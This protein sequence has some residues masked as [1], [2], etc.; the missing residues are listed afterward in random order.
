MDSSLLSQIQKGSR[1]KKAVTNDR[2]APLV[3]G[4]PKT[5]A[6]GATPLSPVSRDSGSASI[7]VANLGGLFAQGMPK[8]RS[9]GGVSTGRIDNDPV[10]ANGLTP[11]KMPAIPGRVLPQPSPSTR[12]MYSNSVSKSP[13]PPLNGLR[14]SHSSE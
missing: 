1:L 2:S 12:P 10:Q 3:G 4:G 5:T 13:N 14:S 8:L 9:R 6:V 11:S 7:P